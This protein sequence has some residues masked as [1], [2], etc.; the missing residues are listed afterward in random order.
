MTW[1]LDTSTMVAP[2]YAYFNPIPGNLF[3]VRL[4]LKQKSYLNKEKEKNI[5]KY[6]LFHC[7]FFFYKK[8]G[9]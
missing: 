4:K 8:I 9:N 3:N 5:Y 2:L 6:G 7:R 1:E